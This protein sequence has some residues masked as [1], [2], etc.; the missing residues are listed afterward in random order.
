MIQAESWTLC[1]K[2]R[3]E[4]LVSSRTKRTHRDDE[5]KVMRRGSH[6]TDVTILPGPERAEASVVL[7][8]L[9]RGKKLEVSVQRATTR[10]SPG[11]WLYRLFENAFLPQDYPNSVPPDYASFQLWDTLQGFCSY[12]RGK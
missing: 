6:G 10:F 12:V 2:A 7:P 8:Q 5:V 11:R 1:Y 3:G 4:L 9:S